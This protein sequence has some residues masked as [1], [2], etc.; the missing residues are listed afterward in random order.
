MINTRGCFHAFCVDAIPID[1]VRIIACRVQLGAGDKGLPY[2]RHQIIG[3]TVF[4]HGVYHIA[5]HIV[6]VQV[7]GDPSLAG[8]DIKTEDRSAFVFA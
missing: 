1:I 6:N 4:A 7:R 3:R 2:F 5:D 8:A